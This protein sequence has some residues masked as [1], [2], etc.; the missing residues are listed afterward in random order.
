MRLQLQ[1]QQHRQMF[2]PCDKLLFYGLVEKFSQMIVEAIVVGALLRS[3]DRLAVLVF[4]GEH[5]R[6]F[7]NRSELFFALR[8]SAAAASETLRKTIGSVLIP[9]SSGFRVSS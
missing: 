9:Q 4:G 7:R 3:N 2:R 8:P 6:Q 5:F 1:R